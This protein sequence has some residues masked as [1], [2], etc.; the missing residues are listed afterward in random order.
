MSG[1]AAERSYM[2]Q[3]ST[4]LVTTLRISNAI[5]QMTA[6]TGGAGLGV[7]P[8]FMARMEPALV[9]VLPDEVDLSR[10]YWLVLHA[11][12]RDVARVRMLADFIR[13]E[14]A[15]ASDFWGA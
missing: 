15:A 12:T 4:A 2:P 6:V 9:R 11:E 5:S 10:S 13:A 1:R 8:C 3:I 14:A 7:L